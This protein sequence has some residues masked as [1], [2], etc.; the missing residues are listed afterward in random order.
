MI[1]RTEVEE[2]FHENG[3]IGYRATRGILH[4]SSA[5]LYPERR[6]H[7]DGYYW[8]YCGI[9]GKWDVNGKQMWVLNYNLKGEL[10]KDSR[11]EIIK[12]Y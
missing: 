12:E 2:I 10:M 7:P 9:V 11:L 8:I 1:L 6:Q 3:K 5:Y 4:E